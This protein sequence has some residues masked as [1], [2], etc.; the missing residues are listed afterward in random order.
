MC[1]AIA[2]SQAF[3]DAIACWIVQLF[4]CLC[5]AQCPGTNYFTNIKQRMLVEFPAV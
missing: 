4:W 3:L 5:P 2:F 1:L